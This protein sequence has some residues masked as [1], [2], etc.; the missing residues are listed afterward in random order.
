MVKIQFDKVSSIYKA[1]LLISIN[2]KKEKIKY[3]HTSIILN[4][5][6]RLEIVL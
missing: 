6:V 1:D 3:T 5:Q 2:Q 4:A